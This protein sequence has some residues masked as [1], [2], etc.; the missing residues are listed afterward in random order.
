MLALGDTPQGRMMGKSKYDEN[1]TLP[2]FLEIEETRGQRQTNGDKFA[3]GIVKFAGKTGTN[4]V[5]GIAGTV[6]GLGSAIANFDK[7]KFF[8]KNKFSIFLCCG[9]LS[10]KIQYI[11]I[12]FFPPNNNLEPLYDQHAI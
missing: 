9:Q 11:F 6:Y 8:D 4:V 5:G 1:L 7:A 2:A 10:N 3:N 12:I